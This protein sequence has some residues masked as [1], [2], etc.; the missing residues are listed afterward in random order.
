MPQES[1]PTR[2]SGITQSGHQLLQL[3]GRQRA[4]GGSGAARRWCRLPLGGASES[5]YGLACNP[6]KLIAN[7]TAQERTQVKTLF[8]ICSLSCGSRHAAR[9][10]CCRMPLGRLVDRS[11]HFDSASDSL[12]RVQFRHRSCRVPVRIE[13]ITERRY[14]QTFCGLCGDLHWVVVQVSCC[15]LRAPHGQCPNVYIPGAQLSLGR[16]RLR[17]AG[18]GAAE[19]RSQAAWRT[20]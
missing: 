9:P 18:H 7:A 13:P 14:V 20:E 5:R 19:R 11:P 4:G 1:A 10:S 16:G 17:R 15:M 6:L 12:L 2:A 8:V 3:L